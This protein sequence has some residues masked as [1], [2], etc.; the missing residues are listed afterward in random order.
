MWLMIITWN[1]VFLVPHNKTSQKKEKKL[2]YLY[3]IQPTYV[4]CNKKWNQEYCKVRIYL[5]FETLCVG[6]IPDRQIWLWIKHIITNQLIN[7]NRSKGLGEI[8]VSPHP[9]IM[10][11][12]MKCAFLFCFLNFYFILFFVFFHFFSQ[13]SC[14]FFKLLFFF[15]QISSVFFF[16]FF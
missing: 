11:I 2:K 6:L 13:L 7:R 3:S 16:F 10:W 14:F 12:T 15:F 8:T 1:R 5:W 4:I 9:N